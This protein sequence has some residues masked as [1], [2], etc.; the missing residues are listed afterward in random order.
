MIC[1]DHTRTSVRVE[2]TQAW[3]PR[4]SKPSVE[5]SG[6]RDWTGVLG[7]VSED[8]EEF[9]CQSDEY[10][11]SEH[12]RQFI[13]ALSK[14]FDEDLIVVLDGAPYFRAS[15]V[16]ELENREG[17][18]LVQ[19]PPYSP[20]MNPVEECWRQLK[21]SLKN[22]FFED[23]DELKRAIQRGLDDIVIPNTSNYL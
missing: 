17:L 4:G 5:L 14:E 6:Q 18:D 19:L 12:A 7:A 20:D 16:T 11:T 1:I 22:R 10:I 13:L 21:A 2:P 15:K 23:L 9:Y 8:G 3:F